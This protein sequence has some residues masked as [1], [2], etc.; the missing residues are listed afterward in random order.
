MNNKLRIKKNKMLHYNSI[1]NIGLFN[2]TITT[3]SN[4]V[5]FNCIAKYI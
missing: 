2:F 4:D 3:E 1:I 5:S